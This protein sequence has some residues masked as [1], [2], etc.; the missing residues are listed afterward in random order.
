[1]GKYYFEIE[2]THRLENRPEKHPRDSRE[3]DR[4]PWLIVGLGNP[5]GEYE[6]TRHNVGFEAVLALAGRWGVKLKKSLYAPAV[7]ASADVEGRAVLLVMPF[8]FMNLSGKAVRPLL[9]SYQTPVEHLLIIYDDVALPFGRLRIRKS[10]RDG[11]HNGMKSIIASLG[12]N[13][14]FPRLRIGVDAPTGGGAELRDHV[15]EAFS[16]EEA[17]RLPD[18]LAVTAEAVERILTEGV[19]AAMNAFNGKTI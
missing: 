17:K 11:G 5:G 3:L 15:L 4:E 7:T 18:I 13:T 9:D 1:M 10:G 6:G 14:G 19:A 2:A 16:P 8:T 12:G